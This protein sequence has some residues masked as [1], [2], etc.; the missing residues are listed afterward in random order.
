M[1][2]CMG[3]RMCGHM[4][5]CVQ[6]QVRGQPPVSLLRCRPPFAGDR[7]HLLGWRLA[8]QA[9]LTGHEVAGI[10]LSTSLMS[11]CSDFC[12]SSEDA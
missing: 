7:I 2:V 9:R 12:V 10:Y 4:H 6:V 3:V 5:T 11:P 1:N 8:K